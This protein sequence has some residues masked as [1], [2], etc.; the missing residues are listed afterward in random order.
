MFVLPRMMALFDVAGEL[1]GEVVVVS[2]RDDGPALFAEAAAGMGDVRKLAVGDRV[3]A[4]TVLHLTDALSPERVVTGSALVNELRRTKSPEELAVMERACRVC[5]DTIAAVAPKVRPGATMLELVEEL[6][7]RCGCSARGCRPS[8]P[9]SS[10]ASWAARTPPRRAAASP[11]RR[12]T[13]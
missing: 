9:T 12:E 3:W 4:E 10:R 11:S 2:E 6:E 8:R 1:P 5:D 13:S 7:H